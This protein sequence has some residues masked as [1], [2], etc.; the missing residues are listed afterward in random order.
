M[1]HSTSTVSI[2]KQLLITTD[3]A[4]ASKND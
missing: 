3:I 1:L 2:T 4:T